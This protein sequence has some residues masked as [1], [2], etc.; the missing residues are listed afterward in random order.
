MSQRLGF[1]VT[2]HLLRHACAVHMIE[3]GADFDEVQR[4][5]GHRSTRS[6]VVYSQM[7]TAVLNRKPKESRQ[8][9]R[10]LT[11]FSSLTELPASPA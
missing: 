5:L 6:A 11:H 9:G 4:R 7:A 1:R 10:K 2:P 8:K 3:A